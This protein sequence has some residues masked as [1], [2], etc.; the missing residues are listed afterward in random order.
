MSVTG[1]HHMNDDNEL[2]GMR[3]SLIAEGAGVHM[4]RPAEAVMARG[5]KLR[6]RRRLLRG[7]SG[8]T[9]AS[10]ALALALT[11]P[12]GGAGFRQVHVNETDWSVNTNRDGSV[13]L[14]V[15]KAADP[16][17]LEA[18]LSQAGVAAT[19]GWNQR[20]GIPSLTVPSRSVTYWY[21]PASKTLRARGVVAGNWTV[22]FQPHQRPSHTV[23]YVGSL[24]SKSG[25][26]LV[27]RILV[28]VV[29]STLHP[30][31]GNHLHAIPGPHATPTGSPHPTATPRPHP[32]CSP[33]PTASPSPSPHGTLSPLPTRTA[34]PRPAATA[35]PSRTATPRPHPSCSP[36]PTASP[37]PHRTPRPSGTPSPYFSPSP[38]VTPASSPTAG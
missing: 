38:Q 22:R 23:Y 13:I 9:A 33:R 28:T 20:C 26:R 3:E 17:G 29:P 7:L 4:D 12:G 10:T 6:L 34:R 25:H 27:W 24:T 1:G 30:A 35:S 31:C 37:S 18:V 36:R 32:S 8:V 14:Q 5:Q 19:V 2:S 15:R 21:A 16:I 11:L